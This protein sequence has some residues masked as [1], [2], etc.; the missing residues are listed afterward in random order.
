MLI[1]SVPNL[2][3]CGHLELCAAVFLATARKKRRGRSGN[4]SGDEAD[5][6]VPPEENHSQII[7]YMHNNTGEFPDSFL[8]SVTQALPAGDMPADFADAFNSLQLGQVCCNASLHCM[9]QPA[10]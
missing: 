8:R 6:A 7:Q 1:I 5:G 10:V 9:A 2:A 3:P 4:D